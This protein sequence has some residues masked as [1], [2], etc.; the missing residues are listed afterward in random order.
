MT[1]GGGGGGGLGDVD[2]GGRRWLDIVDGTSAGCMKAWEE[3][4]QRPA[5]PRSNFEEMLVI[6]SR[7][8]DQ[9]DKVCCIPWCDWC[10]TGNG[11]FV[12]QV[13]GH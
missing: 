8:R 10:R 11:T 1:A 2:A 13:M 6:C 9:S 7:D 4:R 12:E 5:G 3:E